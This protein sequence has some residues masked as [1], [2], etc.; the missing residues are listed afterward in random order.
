MNVGTLEL[1]EAFL[2][3]ASFCSPRVDC[4]DIS[5]IIDDE[6]RERLTFTRGRDLMGH[7]CARTPSGATCEISSKP[8]LDPK[9]NGSLKMII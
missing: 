7:V 2:D 5:P 4:Y 8:F 1:C 3:D 9:H 6:K